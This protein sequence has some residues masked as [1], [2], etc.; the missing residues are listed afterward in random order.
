MKK[1]IPIYALLSA[2]SLIFSASCNDKNS[3]NDD[4]PITVSANTL[5]SN[6]NLLQDDSIMAMLDSVKFTVDVNRRVIYNADSLPKG[7]KINRLL[8]SITFAES[9]S[10]GEISISGATTMNDTTFTYNSSASDSI[11][12]TG[13]VYLTVTAADN[14]SS[15]RYEL[16]VNVHQMEADS[17]YWNQLARRNLPANSMEVDDQKTVEKGGVFYCLVKSR[18]S[19]TLSTTDNPGESAWTVNKVSFRFTP[20]VSSL[21]A[22]DDALYILADDRTLYRSADNGATWTSTRR[23][24]NSLI[25]GYGTQLLAISSQNG[26][27]YHDGYPAIEKVEIDKDFPVDGFSQAG[28]Y[29][30]DWG[31]SEQIFI[32]GGIRQDGTPTGHLW[33]YDGQNWQ[34]LSEKSVPALSGMTLIPYF[35]YLQEDFEYEKYPVLLAMG[36]RDINGE[37]SKKVY[38]SYDNGINWRLGDD[39]LQL[40]DYI[41]EFYGAQ[42]FVAESTMTVQTRA[43]GSWT[44][45]E[46]R[47]LPFWW[48]IDGMQQ[49]RASQPVTSWECPFIYVF[50]GYNANGSLQNNIWKGVINRLTFKP[51]I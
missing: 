29:S 13:K 31:T 41:S 27:Y 20:I 42:A 19:Y 4:E 37:L 50:G 30:S 1:L 18:S 22:T 48:Q 32:I 5:V 33:G 51:I 46:S 36:G 12:F 21:C 26:V 2:I 14:I 34:R 25:A 28:S 44:P 45:I 49:T 7:T 47:R 17:L 35:N 11:D 23:S 24:F 16:K 3:G 38:I 39:L 6:F 8:A 15:K 43:A 9:T 40:P 10:T